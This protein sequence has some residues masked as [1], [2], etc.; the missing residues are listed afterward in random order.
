MKRYLQ[1][2]GEVLLI[3]MGL[4]VAAAVIVAVG[5]GVG[6]VADSEMLGIG[7]SFA[8]VLLGLAALVAWSES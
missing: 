1:A 4:L 3:S 6:S 5:V 8:L 7:A 2:L